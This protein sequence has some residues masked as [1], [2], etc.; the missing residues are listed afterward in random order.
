[1]L[2]D[3]RAIDAK[4]GFQN[5][6]LDAINLID[7]EMRLKRLDLDLIDANAV[8]YHS[9]FGAK[10]ISRR[11]LINFCFH[12]EQLSRAG[13]PLLEGLADLRDSLE[14]PRFRETIASLIEGIEGGQTLSQAME[15][16]ERISLRRGIGCR[17]KST[18][19]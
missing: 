14:N 17:M 13:V 15:N 18:S 3:Y 8:R 19:T 12:L 2:F 4:G 7:L 9:L 1:M 10:K 16:Q 5:G 6:R 11:E